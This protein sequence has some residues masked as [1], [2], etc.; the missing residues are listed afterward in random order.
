MFRLEF[1]RTSLTDTYHALD[2]KKPNPTGTGS[3]LPDAVAAVTKPKAA[4]VTV[5]KAD[6]KADPKAVALTTPKAVPKVAK[7]KTKAAVAAPPPRMQPPPGK[8][9]V[10]HN[11]LSRGDEPKQK[12]ITEM[13]GLWKQAQAK[14]I[15]GYNRMKKAELLQALA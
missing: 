2:Q 1:P 4:A 9:R 10:I 7:P 6:P 12:R 14:G 8:L 15:K 5:Q 11:L 13:S 3:A